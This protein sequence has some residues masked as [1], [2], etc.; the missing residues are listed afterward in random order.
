MAPMPSSVVTTILQDLHA[1]DPDA[2]ERLVRLV[3]DELRR[4]AGGF[5]RGERPSHTWQ[6]TDLVHEALARLLGADVLEE[7]KNRQHFFGVAARTMRRLLIEHARMRNAGKRQGQ[8]QRVPLDDVADYFAQQ[9]LDV[10]ALHEALE[11]LATLNERQSEVV[12]LRYYFRFTVAEI[13]Q[14]LEVSPSTVESDMRFTVAWLRG[15]LVGAQ[16]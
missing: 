15:Q 4:M 2:Q 7:T 8:W 16:P 6:P 12:T 13:A 9:N 3:Y 1:G 5:L 11:C 14:Q 10:V